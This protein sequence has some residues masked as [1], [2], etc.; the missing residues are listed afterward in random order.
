MIDSPYFVTS[1][2]VK[3]IVYPHQINNEIRNNIKNNINK[4]LKNK[5][6]KNYGYIT[7][8]YSIQEKIGNGYLI[9]EDSSASIHYNINFKAKL[10]NPIINSNICARIEG[11]NRHMIMCKNGPINIVI[12][13]ENIN[14]EKFTYNSSKNVYF[15]LDDKKKEIKTPLIEGTFII[16]KIINKRIID[17][18]KNIIVLGKLENIP[19]NDI[20][21]SCIDNDNKNNYIRIDDRLNLDNQIYDNND[22]N[23][24]NDQYVEEEQNSNDDNLI[25]ESDIPSDNESEE[26]INF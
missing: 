22:N 7:D 18:E 26:S 3:T 13:S 11:I 23:D 19:S 9:P 17:Q 20:V 21:K 12:T 15:P 24:D 25:I 5:C 2:N 4:K 16:C 14:N 8:I 6:F 1:L 10:C